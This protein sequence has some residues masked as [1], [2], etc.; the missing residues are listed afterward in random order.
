V[1][2]PTW[3]WWTTII[4]TVSVLLF[5]I[6]VIGRRPHEPSTRRCRSR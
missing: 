6:V 1:D 3:V 2:V 5:D 4:V